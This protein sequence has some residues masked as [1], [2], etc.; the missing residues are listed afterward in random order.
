MAVASRNVKPPMTPD[1]IEPPR[2]KHGELRIPMQAINSRARAPP[3]ASRKRKAEMDQGFVEVDFQPGEHPL[4]LVVDWSMA[5]PVL[6]GVLPGSYAAMFDE[7]RP[8][9]VLLA[10]NNIPLVLGAGRYEASGAGSSHRI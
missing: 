1:V 2:K 5:L 10:I 3:E 8:G 7:L 9:L 4:G 6:S